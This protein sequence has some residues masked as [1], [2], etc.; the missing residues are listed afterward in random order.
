MGIRKDYSIRVC[1]ESNPVYKN[2]KVVNY[3]CGNWKSLD[4]LA[5]RSV[6]KMPN[7]KVERVWSYVSDVDI[8]H[9]PDNS[10]GVVVVKFSWNC[11]IT[12]Y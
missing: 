8:T 11:E 12:T 4:E 9:P 1:E 7:G 10:Y 5:T 2:E 3:K 6:T